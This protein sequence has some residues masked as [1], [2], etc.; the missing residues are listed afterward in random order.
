MSAVPP[1]GSLDEL[2]FPQLLLRLAA[3]RFGGSLRLSR[4]RVSKR[5]VFQQG[6]PVMAESN[7]AGESL[8]ELLRDQGRLTPAD[9]E[10]LLA[11]SA[12]S[13][14]A[15]EAL[16]L[17]RGLL[18]ARELFDALK[19][20]L[21]MRVIEC[22]AWPRGDFA[23]DS[24]SEAPPEAQAF[25]LNVFGLLQEGL[26]QHW[27]AER[28]LAELAPHMQQHP[29]PNARFEAIARLLERDA[30]IEALLARFDGRHT[31]WQCLQ[32]GS[33]RALATAWILEASGALGFRNESSA[34]SVAGPLTPEIEIVIT[35]AAGEAA[36]EAQPRTA[37]AGAPLSEAATKQ[38]ERLLTEIEAKHARL[39]ELSAYELLDV[40][41]DA[42]T[43]AIRKAYLQAA[44]RFHPDALSRVGLG[45]ELRERATRVFAEI[46]KAHTLL[47]DPAERQQYDQS[48]RSLQPE[49]DVGRL[50]QAETLYRKGEILLRQG[51]FRGALEFLAPAVELWPEECA[52]QSA[53]GWALFRKS[54]PETERALEH[55]RRAVELDANDAES[56]IRLSSVERSLQGG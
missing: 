42:E 49:I 22:F 3:A 54:P 21:R 15:P 45:A 31:L 17:E 4:G 44:K 25:R 28:L 2:P 34:A 46:S 7:L 26:D 55:L 5:I 8:L 36:A 47:A 23:T 35:S 6:A 51:N 29:V 50:A 19:R 43:G 30:G 40:P 56:Q 12:S 52:Y 16:L 20:L 38:R 37:A 41:E 24:S 48:R 33:G 1:S 53:L 39:K 32:G 14:R 18:D 10:A 11:Q 27:G 9:C 13:K